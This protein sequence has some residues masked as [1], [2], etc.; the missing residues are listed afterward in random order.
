MYSLRKQGFHVPDEVSVIGFDDIPFASYF[1]PTLTTVAQPAE[2]I[3]ITCATLL[4]DLI[5]GHKP[6]KLRHIL[7]HKL[8]VRQ[9]TGPLK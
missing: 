4:L 7:E 9:S 2:Q 5:D 8:L 1:A 3:G 6:K